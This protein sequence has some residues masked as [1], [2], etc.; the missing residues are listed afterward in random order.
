[1]LVLIVDD[2]NLIV[3]MTSR[4]VSTIENITP[5]GFTD[6]I[7]ALAWCRLNEPDVVMVDYHMPELDGLEFIREF[8]SLPGKEATPII[9]VTSET[10]ETLK[11]RALKLG[12]NDFISKP[13]KLPELKAR[14]MKSL[15]FLDP[16]RRRAD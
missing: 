7:Q 10:D 8:R 11:H 13:V 9:M 14:I 4:L 12:A 1:M 15:E 2:D 3:E 16:S 5:A 6:P